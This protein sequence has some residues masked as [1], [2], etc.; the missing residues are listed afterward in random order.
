MTTT[1]KQTG[2]VFTLWHGGSSYAQPE[3]SQLE[4]FETID[5][6]VTVPFDA[7]AGSLSPSAPSM[8][9]PAR[10]HSRSFLIA[11]GRISSGSAMFGSQAFSHSSVTHPL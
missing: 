11:S 10:V 3:H 4:R 6:V 1:T 9:S 5:R 2:P 7:A 8:S